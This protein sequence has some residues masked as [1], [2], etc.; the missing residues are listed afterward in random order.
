M[1]SKT[2]TVQRAEPCLDGDKLDKCPLQPP[3]RETL[4]YTNV[5][6][7]RD[8]KEEVADMVPQVSQ[9]TQ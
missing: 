9:E 2:G 4:S 7:C 8:P 5:I 3:L 1:G 6:A